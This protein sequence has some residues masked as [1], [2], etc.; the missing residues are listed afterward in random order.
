MRLL[1]E[2]C[3]LLSQKSMVADFSLWLEFSNHVLVL[4]LV[5]GLE[6]E[7]ENQH[8]SLT[9]LSIVLGTNINPSGI[10]IYELHF[11]WL[12]GKHMEQF[13]FLSYSPRNQG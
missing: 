12:L 5:S 8:K 6:R 4:L 2:P 3:L 13:Y 10:D 7:Q 11:L 1:V 9:S